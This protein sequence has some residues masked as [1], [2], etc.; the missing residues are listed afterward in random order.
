MSKNKDQVW[1]TKYGVRRVRHEAPTLEEAIAAAQ[2]LSDELKQ[3]A[4]IAAALIRLPLDQVRTEL[5]KVGSLRKGV[6]KSFTFTGPTSAQRTIVVER[7]PARRV[8]AAA[9][10]RWAR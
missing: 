10:H 8:I 9:D 2:G 5:L 7:R 6:I 1:K 4:E 3:Q